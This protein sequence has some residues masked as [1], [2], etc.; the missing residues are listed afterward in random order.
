MRRCTEAYVVRFTLTCRRVGALYSFSLTP[1]PR[2]LLE[3]CGYV[4]LVCFT[5]FIFLDNNFRI[6][7]ILIFTLR[8]SSLAV[9]QKRES[10]LALFNSSLCFL[11]GYRLLRYHALILWLYFLLLR[12]HLLPNTNHIPVSVNNGI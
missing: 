11:A 9:W 7:M 6:N 1:T 5:Y 10:S 8:E 2:L 12:N 3:S 4:L